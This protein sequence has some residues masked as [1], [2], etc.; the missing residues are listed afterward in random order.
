MPTRLHILFDNPEKQYGFMAMANHP[1]TTWNGTLTEV[2]QL[3][4]R[5]WH[6]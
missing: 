2:N 1:E 5:Q 3:S 4:A 6:S